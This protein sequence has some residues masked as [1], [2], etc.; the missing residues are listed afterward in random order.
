SGKRQ[1]SLEL[2]L[3]LTRQLGVRIDDLV[4]PESPD[5]RVRRAAIRRDGLTI[6]PLAPEGSPI[7]TYRITYPP[8]D[9]L[10][11]L[12]VHDGYEWLYVLSGRLR[13]RLGDQDLSL[14][15]GEAAEFDTRTPHSISAAGSR[16]A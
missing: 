1:A 7:H 6:A 11:D 9:A 13:L 16:P 14:T 12:R 8:V 15:R 10:P 3:P 5:P 2:L 4:R